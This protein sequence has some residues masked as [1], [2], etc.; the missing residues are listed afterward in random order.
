MYNLYHIAYE[1]METIDMYFSNQL[2]CFIGIIGILFQG[3]THPGA[4]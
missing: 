3:E 4:I 2:V 1:L